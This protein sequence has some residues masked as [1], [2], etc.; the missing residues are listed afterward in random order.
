MPRGRSLWILFVVG[1]ALAYATLLQP[2]GCN[3]TAHYG[4]MQSLYHGTPRIDR[5]HDET[6]DTAYIDGHYF[7]AKA[8]GLALVTLPW[9][10]A[11]RVA[12]AVPRNGGLGRGF[13]AAMLSLPRRALWQ[14]GL[15]G[16]VLPALGL[17]L[18]VGA[19]GERLVS[20][21]GLPTAATVGLGTLI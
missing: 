13:P 4:L 17:L 8:P 2:P 18:L 20:G 19:V 15:F 14:V 16:A 3:Q 11:L 1:A 6:C 5:F 10:A 9:F 21:M 12:G 7:A